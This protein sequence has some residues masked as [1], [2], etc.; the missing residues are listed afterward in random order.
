MPV[1]QYSV[2]AIYSMIH[3]TKRRFLLVY[4]G[5]MRRDGSPGVD[6]PAHVRVRRHECLAALQKPLCDCH[7]HSPNA[8]NA[9]PY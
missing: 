9:L 4:G 5:I 3:R 6:P 1:C 8:L 7:R 2:E